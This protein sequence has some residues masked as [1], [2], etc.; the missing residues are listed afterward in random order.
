MSLFFPVPVHHHYGHEAAMGRGYRTHQ[1]LPLRLSL[2]LQDK[3][4]NVVGVLMEICLPDLRK[5][6]KINN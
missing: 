1:G 5:L 6:I 3:G 4:D 2:E